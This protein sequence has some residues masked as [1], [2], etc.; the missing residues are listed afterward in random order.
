[1]RI[2]GNKPIVARYIGN[3]PVIARYVGENRIFPPR[4]YVR[5]NLY[6]HFDA[7]DNQ[8]TGVHNPSATTWVDLAGG[9]NGTLMGACVWVGDAVRTGDTTASKV[10]FSGVLPTGLADYT[11]Q[12]TVSLDIKTATNPYLSGL[13]PYPNV[14]AFSTNSYK[15]SW[16]SSGSDGVISP[17]KIW[18]TA[19]RVSLIV[20]YDSVARTVSFFE[21][22]VYIGGRTNINKATSVTYAWLG[23]REANDRTW[24]GRIS[25]YMLYTRGLTDA[26]I[27]NNYLVDKARFGIT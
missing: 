6:T 4:D 16:Y 9:R 18:P 15:Y 17:E 10:R 3:N 21:N 5:D 1:M 12:Y 22:G 8:G 13:Q 27:M 7:L 14:Y 25:N 26:E 2:I 23:G 11:I 19:K 24:Q 20:R